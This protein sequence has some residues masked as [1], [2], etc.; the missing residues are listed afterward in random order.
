MSTMTEG[1]LEQVDETVGLWCSGDS[2][3]SA[4]GSVIRGDCSRYFEESKIVFLA[5]VL[6]GRSVGELFLFCN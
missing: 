4:S 2:V 6:E 3:L 5:S 1:A